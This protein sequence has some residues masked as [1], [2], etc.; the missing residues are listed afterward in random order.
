M[1][2]PQVFQSLFDVSHVKHLHSAALVTIF[3]SA[4]FL[5]ISRFLHIN[6]CKK[7]S[8]LMPF[9]IRQ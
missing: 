1:S 7:N 4:F 3:Y 8:I 2:K 6:V 5:L 9:Y